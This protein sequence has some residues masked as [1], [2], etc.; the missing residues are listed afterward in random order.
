[1]VV[2]LLCLIVAIMLFGSSKVIGGFGRIFGFIAIVVGLIFL[3]NATGFEALDIL[4]VIFLLFI[5]GCGY[6]YIFHR[7]EWDKAKKM[8]EMMSKDKESR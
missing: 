4:R 2:F 6:F 3:S 1:M 7:E 8:N 5:G